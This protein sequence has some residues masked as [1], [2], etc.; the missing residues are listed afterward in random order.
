MSLV[1]LGMALIDAV[2]SGDRS[3]VESLLESGADPNTADLFD[4]LTAL[5]HARR[6]GHDEVARLLLDRGASPAERRGSAP[7]SSTAPCEPEAGLT[8][9]A[10]L[11]QLAAMIG[12]PGAD[13]A[14]CLGADVAGQVE[15]VAKKGRGK[16]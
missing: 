11:A 2:K 3:A 7:E 8:R 6:G 10:L 9:E 13:V 15:A 5:D 4:G 1:A 14:A 12:G 16:A